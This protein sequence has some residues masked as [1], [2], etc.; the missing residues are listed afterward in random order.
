MKSV[1]YKKNRNADNKLYN[2]RRGIMTKLKCD[3]C[4]C[5]H[6][7]D[8]CCCLD[9]IKVGGKQATEQEHTCCESF[10]ESDGSMTNSVQEPV[11]HMEIGCHAT[12]CVHNNDC[13]CKADEICICGDHACDC[14]ETECSSFCCK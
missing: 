12:N 7:N 4:T 14:N 13:K 8:Y 2:V 11:L 5:E 3:A 1:L 6:N 10:A 9:G